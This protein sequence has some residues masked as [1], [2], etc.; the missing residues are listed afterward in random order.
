MK[1]S[2]KTSCLGILAGQE[3]YERPDGATNGS[4]ST[5]SMAIPKLGR[6]QEA[7]RKAILEAFPDPRTA[8]SQ[9]TATEKAQ[10]NDRNERPQTAAPKPPTEAERNTTAK[11]SKD[12][13]QKVDVNQ[14]VT[15]QHGNKIEMVHSGEVR[16]L[17]SEIEVRQVMTAIF[18]PIILEI[19]RNGGNAA[20]ALQKAF[21]QAKA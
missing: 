1:I 15:I 8:G 11:A 3:K 17:A 18:E 19:Q 7:M 14:Q 2:K 10:P 4:N 13:P 5:E 12:T 20:A 21:P 9:P 6:F 16:G